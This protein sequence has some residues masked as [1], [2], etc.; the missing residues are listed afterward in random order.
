MNFQFWPSA[1]FV[2]IPTV[3][4]T[5]IVLLLLNWRVNTMYVC[6]CVQNG[7]SFVNY[8]FKG[9]WPLQITPSNKYSHVVPKGR[10]HGLPVLRAD[11][12]FTSL[13]KKATLL[14]DTSYP[15]PPLNVITI[16]SA[17]SI[18]D[19]PDTADS[20]PPSWGGGRTQHRGL[21]PFPYPSL[22]LLAVSMVRNRYRERYITACES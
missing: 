7:R 20:A 8:R 2:I 1:A 18:Q 12:V 13:T 4:N 5:D 16:K 14:W 6:I 15:K 21:V 11:L 17:Q 9:C 22:L 3:K 10:T 19:T